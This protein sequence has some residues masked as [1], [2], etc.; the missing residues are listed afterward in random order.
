MDI[1]KFFQSKSF[2]IIIVCIAVAVSLFFVFS[3]G[4]FVGTQKADFSF[5]WAEQYHRNFAGPANGF[6]QQF[7]GK[8]FIEHNGVFGKIIKVNE[9]S[10][11]VNGRNDVEKIILVGEKTTIKSLNNNVN[12]SDLKVDDD[13][14]IIGEPNSDG[15]ID[16]ALIRVMPF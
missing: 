1:N 15:Q 6:F 13:V 4:V 5:K 11:I 12:I 9:D 10:I 8:D 16:A 3:L 14:V 7:E 2:K